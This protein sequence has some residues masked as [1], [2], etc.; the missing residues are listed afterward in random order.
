[1][2]PT[3]LLLTAL[4]AGTLLASQ[5]AGAQTIERSA[6][7]A[8]AGDGVG[9]FDAHFGDAFA[10]STAGRGFVDVFTFGA[11]TPFDAAASLTS[12]YLDTPLT[13]DLDIV[14]LSLY[15]YDPSTS[16]ILGNAIAGLNQ[17]GF[18]QH[19]TDAWSLSTFGLPAGSYAL[20]VDGRVSGGGGGVFG[21]DL[22]IAPVPE[23]QAWHMLV[24]GLGVAGAL[25][26][27][28]RR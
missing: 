17:T 13:K 12:L 4:A 14:G 5:G 26:W 3:S 2:K 10:A 23:A 18:G 25:A 15:R 7:L 24:A 22:A 28:R 20:R 9:G 19:P 6:P 11:T 1:M 8:T 21:A 27:R 16:A